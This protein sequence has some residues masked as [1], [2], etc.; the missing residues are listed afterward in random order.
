MRRRVSGGLRSI[1]KTKLESPFPV[2]RFSLIE[3]FWA[4]PGP[5]ETP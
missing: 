2:A 3:G 4:L 1:A 5:P